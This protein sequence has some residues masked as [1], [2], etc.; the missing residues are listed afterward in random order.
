MILR[1]R[2]L[3]A[4]LAAA[5]TLGLAAPVQ[6]ATI[7]YAALGDSYASGT[8]AGNYHS[9]SGN[10]LRSKDSYAEWYR[11]VK[12]AN[13]IFNACSG[14]TTDS[15]AGQTGNL[16][17]GIDLVSVQVGGND[18]GFASVL[19]TCT[20]TTSGPAGDRKCQEAVNAAIGKM[21]TELGGKLDRAYR[22]IRS[23]ATKAKVVVIGYPRLFGL[24]A[25]GGQ[26]SVPKQRSLNDGANHLDSVIRNRAAAAGFTYVDTRDR[27]NFHGVCGPAPWIHG[28]RQP[29][30]ESYHPNAAGHRDGLLPALQQG[31]L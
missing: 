18:I 9:G 7:D 12:N 6:A 20:L 14:A 23:K 26:L 31:A 19:T 29:I 13:L 28:T 16:N 21:N 17:G 8:G 24:R 27:F 30:T 1:T 4:A 25:C 11:F 15:I 5:A 3:A 2:F 22:Q 10:C